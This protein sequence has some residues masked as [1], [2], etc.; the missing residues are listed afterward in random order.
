MQRRL[1]L[2]PTLDVVLPWQRDCRR[3]SVHLQRTRLVQRSPIA[4][5][6]G[7]QV[8]LCLLS[9]LLRLRNHW[10]RHLLLRPARFEASGG[11][12]VAS[13]SN[14]SKL[15]CSPAHSCVSLRVWMRLKVAP[16]SVVYGSPARCG[17]SPRTLLALRGR[18][19]L[20]RVFRSVLIALET[21][22]ERFF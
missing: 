15:R 1:Y 7:H 22:R 4:Q 11:E 10:R 2:R 12:V 16:S 3:T 14:I 18:S 13:V 9:Y 19:R 6:Y 5:L 20:I 8:T 21:S 17:V